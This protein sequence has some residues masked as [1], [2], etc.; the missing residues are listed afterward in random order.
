MP[1]CVQHM[2][3]ADGPVPLRFH[4][5]GAPAFAGVEDSPAPRISQLS[6]AA[7]GAGVIR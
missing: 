3:G 5:G 7:E 2:H 1:P 4:S 6:A